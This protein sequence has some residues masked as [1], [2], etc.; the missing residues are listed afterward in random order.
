MLSKIRDFLAAS[1]VSDPIYIGFLPEGTD[2]AVALFETG[3]RPFDTLARENLRPTFQL[4][5]RGAERDYE[6]ARTR[7]K[8]CFDLLQDASQTSGSPMLLPGFIFIQ[9]MMTGPMPF[10]D[11]NKR[12]NFTTN[13]NVLISR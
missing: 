5:V 12:I 4:R 1:G 13:F 7:W 8:T 2:E 3:G 11:A 6:A 9:A 10:Y